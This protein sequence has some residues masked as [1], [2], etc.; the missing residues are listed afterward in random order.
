MR[1]HLLKALPFAL[2][3]SFVQA[4][5]L[6]E[7]MQQALDVH[8]EIQ[9]GV[10]S[11][12][13]ADYQL[14]AAKGG[15]L[16]RVDL[17]GGYGREGTDSPSTRTGAGSNHW[18]TLNRS[19]SSLRLSQMVFDGF[20]TSSE[21][22]RQQANVNSR[23]YSLLG[24]SERTAL[25]VAQV[26]LDVLTRRDF[27]QLAE[28]NLRNHERI[29]DQIKLRTPRGVGSGA[30][31]DQAQAR[32]AQ[33]RNNLITEQTNLADA[34]TNFLSAVGQMPDQLERP[35][36][37]VALLPA[38]LNEARRQMLENSPI[39]RSAES[40]IVA[41]EKQYEAAKSTFYP[42]FDAELGRTADNDLDGQNGHNNEWQAM[43]RMRF[44][45]F[46]GGSNKADLESKS[47]QSTQA[48]DIRNNALRVLNEEL[49]LAWNALNNANAQV[50]IAQQYV[51]RS[52]S[53]RTSYQKQFSLGERTLLDLLDSENELFSASR[54]LTEIKNIQLFTQ[55]RI[56]A[57]MGELLKSQGVV[58]PMAAVVQ[59]DVKPKVQLPGMN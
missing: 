31:L 15:Y 44:N 47:Y 36:G 26:Y 53:V 38:D 8:P 21:V 22:G 40:D 19:E 54:R 10:N 28:D 37:F 4:Q 42:R 52:T 43:L 33:A 30:D 51:D 3:A 57:T 17:L 29:F 14:K 59:N 49:G 7:A 46:A 34:Q 11:R 24:S 13:S 27:V 5:S 12:L 1:S 50:P 18:E 25:T 20:A 16:P 55:Y 9:A 39:L 58:A 23:A 48:L 32:L 2:V 6:P 56:K 41:A 45:L 35:A